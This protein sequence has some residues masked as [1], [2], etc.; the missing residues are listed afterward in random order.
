MPARRRSVHPAQLSLQFPDLPRDDEPL[1]GPDDDSVFLAVMPDLTDARILA[2]VGDAV[3][4]RLGLPGARRLARTLHVSLLGIAPYNALS[5]A[6]LERVKRAV[7]TVRQPHFIVGFDRVRSLG[8]G[9]TRPLV[10]GG[11]DGVAGLAQL[12][13]ALRAA[14]GLRD[15]PFLP[16]MT[17]LYDRTEIQ[18]T[19]LPEPVTWA[20]RDLVLVRSHYGESRYGVLERWPFD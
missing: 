12:R 13:S 3:G 7:S 1:D 5:P 19:F 18:M 2:E 17:V 15:T 6:V 20:A 10:L 8:S 4:Q 14:L 16:H 9:R 11:D